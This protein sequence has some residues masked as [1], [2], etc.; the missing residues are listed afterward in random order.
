[1][2][3]N[4]KPAVADALNELLAPVQKEFAS[5]P[6]WKEVTEKAYPPPEIKKKEKKPKNRG[7]RFPG[8]RETVEAKPDGHIEGN[9][10]DDVNLDENA[11]K[12]LKDLNMKADGVVDY[13]LENI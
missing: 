9:G 10:K 11:E 2:P 1:M 4:L 5:T 7:T 6:D 8:S 13:P 12:A 3:Q